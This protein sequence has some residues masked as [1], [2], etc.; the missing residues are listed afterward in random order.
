MP[1]WPQADDGLPGKYAKMAQ[2]T[3]NF[4]LRRAGDGDLMRTLL[5]FVGMI[6]QRCMPEPKPE[7]VL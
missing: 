6:V 5:V 7:R 1:R 4:P 2:K 3:P